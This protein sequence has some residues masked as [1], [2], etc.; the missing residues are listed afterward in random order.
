MVKVLYLIRHGQTQWNVQR[1]MQGR[2]D[3]PL[4][5][6]G[7]A[8]AHAHGR[9]LKS[10][11]AIASLFVSPSGRTRETAYIVN[12]YVQ[13]YVDY[14]EE[15]LE[16]D[17]GEWSGM[18]MDEVSESYPAAFRKRQEDPYYFTPPSGENLQDMS[19]R[20]GVFLDDL[21]ANELV[22]VGLVTHQV[23]SRV[24]LSRILKLNEVETNRLVH[25]NDVVYRVDVS[26]GAPEISHFLLG[27]GPRS[28]LLQ[29]SD[30]ETISRRDSRD[31]DHRS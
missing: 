17:L 15:L 23:M 4:T 27:D 30:S 21:L 11:A 5:E 8:Q 2:L 6:A 14:V 3:S 9:L 12:S 13:G 25:P 31:T 24:I 18:T 1:R 22:E 29:H 26:S 7:I 16:R 28:G 19:D 10:N 20:V